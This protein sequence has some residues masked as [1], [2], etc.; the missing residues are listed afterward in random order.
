VYWPSA[1]SPIITSGFSHYLGR[2]RSGPLLDFSA[3]GGYHRS[4]AVLA[5]FKTIIGLPRYRK[6]VLSYML[7][8]ILLKLP[9]TWRRFLFRSE[10]HYCPVCQNPVRKFLPWGD[11]AHVWCPIC[12]AFERHRLA[13]LF[14]QQKTN[15]FDP[16]PKRMLHIA[17]EPVLETRFRSVPNLSYLSVDLQS[18]RAMERMDITDIRYPEGAFD[19]ICCSHVLEHVPED[20]KAMRELYR[21][22]KSGGWAILMVPLIIER[23]IEDPSITRPEDRERLFGQYDHV[24]VYGPDFSERLQKARFKVTIFRAAE[25]V[26][27]VNR[28]GIPASE[29]VFYCEKM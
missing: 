4:V 3:G 19:V 18:S 14:F 12:G 7:R 24:R 27:D 28:V 21:V 2:R 16:S 22:L 26:D 10:A 20:R 1:F 11:I 6:R 23:T 5:K 25:L 9:E 15:L 29:V 13:W 17:P 8:W